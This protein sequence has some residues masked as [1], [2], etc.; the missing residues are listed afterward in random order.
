MRLFTI[1]LIASFIVSTLV[2]TLA[3]ESI[4][5]SFNQGPKVCSECH[6]AEHEIWQGTKNATSFKKV[7]KS[8]KAK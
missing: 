3:N 7:H 4:A 1:S 8:K 5:E 2:F 6:R